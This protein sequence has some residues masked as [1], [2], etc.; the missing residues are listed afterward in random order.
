[1]VASKQ[2]WHIEIERRPHRVRLLVLAAMLGGER[3]GQRLQGDCLGTTLC[4]FQFRPTLAWPS[5]WRPQFPVGGHPH[6]AGYRQSILVEERAVIG[7]LI[8]PPPIAQAGVR[9][10]MGMDTEPDAKYLERRQ[11]AIGT[12]RFELGVLRAAINWAHKNGR[13]TRSVPVTLPTAPAPRERWLTRQEAARLIR[14]ARTQKARLY[15]PLFILIGLYTGRRK[16][17]IL[18]LR[19]TQIDLENGLIDFEVAGRD[20]TK[21]RRGKVRIPARLLPHLRRARRRGTDLGYVLHINGARIGN[22][23]RG[24]VAARTR[25]GLKGVSP[26]TLRHTAATWLMQAG[27]PIWEASGFLA[28]SPQTLQSVYGHHHPDYMREAADAIG[29]RPQNV[30]VIG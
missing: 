19:W 3:I 21:K 1:V 13:L 29:R 15:M 20:R 18:S 12:M 27:V 10:V 28:M 11:R 24:F 2:C 9:E 23:K 30:R 17:A 8:R 25:A 14:A 22:I 6:N 16:E 26:H 5:P 4:S 7:R